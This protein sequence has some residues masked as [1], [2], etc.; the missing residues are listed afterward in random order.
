MPSGKSQAQRDQF[1][2][3]APL[4]DEELARTHA[5]SARRPPDPRG[6]SPH[7]CGLRPTKILPAC[8]R[9][10]PDDVATYAQ[11]SFLNFTQS[12][13]P[14]R[15]HPGPP[16]T[17]SRAGDRRPAFSSTS[18]TLPPSFPC[19]SFSRSACVSFPSHHPTRFFTRPLF[20]PFLFFLVTLFCTCVPIR[21]SL[22]LVSGPHRV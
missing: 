10:A 19:P 16:P 1:I 17:S 21:F 4:T 5:G 11:S 7:P 6:F 9:A 12:S 18:R 3:A 22:R 20:F 2:A 8:M 14:S 13:S 15:F